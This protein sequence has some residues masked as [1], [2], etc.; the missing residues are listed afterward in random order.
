MSELYDSLLSEAAVNFALNGCLGALAGYCVGSALKKSDIDGRTKSIP[1]INACNFSDDLKIKYSLDSNFE[2]DSVIL[3][4]A[5]ELFSIM[6]NGLHSPNKTLKET[7]SY[8]IRN[9]TFKV[10]TFTVLTAYGANSKNNDIYNF[11]AFIGSEYISY[12]LS[13]MPDTVQIY[14]KRDAE[15]ALKAI[16][17]RNHLNNHPYDLDNNNWCTLF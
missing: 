2:L 11:C 13:R 9:H 15:Q 7:L 4:C 5:S 17:R 8:I 12:K 16:E 14:T 10:L 6:T 3:H 1:K